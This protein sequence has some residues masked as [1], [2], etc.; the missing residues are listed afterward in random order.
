MLNTL[1]RQ[2]I[3]CVVSNEQ[4]DNTAK[5]H[6]LHFPINMFCSVIVLC[7]KTKLVI[8]VSWIQ[9]F[10]N[11]STIMHGLRSKKIRI[12]YSCDRNRHP[13]FGQEP[14]K[15]FSHQINGC[16]D[17]ICLKVFGKVY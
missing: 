12:F 13:T 10:L 14:R 2:L 15:F 11:A 6:F 8:P 9:G 1:G 17:A 5:I 16:Y 4:R 3:Y 7:S